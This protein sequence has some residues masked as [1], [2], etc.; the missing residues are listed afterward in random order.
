MAG[1]R[2]LSKGILLYNNYSSLAPIIH[3]KIPF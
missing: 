3:F 2:G 1:K